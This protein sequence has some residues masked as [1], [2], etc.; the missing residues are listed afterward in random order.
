[1]D[2]STAL[3]KAQHLSNELSDN[4]EL[5][6]ITTALS[7]KLND[8]FTHLAGAVQILDDMQ[9]ASPKQAAAFQLLKL[10]LKR[11]AVNLNDVSDILEALVYPSR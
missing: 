6:E 9:A 1:M 11:D 4:F 5:K 7:Q 3:S 2:N 10:Q 8:S